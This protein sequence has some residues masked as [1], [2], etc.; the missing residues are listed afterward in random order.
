LSQHIQDYANVTKMIFSVTG[1]F[2]S[3]TSYW[4][5]VFNYSPSNPSDK[6]WQILGT[7][8]GSQ[9]TKT[10]IFTISGENCMDFIDEN[11]IVKTWMF[12]VDDLPE[13]A[14]VFLDQAKLLVTVIEDS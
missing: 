7:I 1:I 10:W 5:N 14:T 2:P 9:Q 8:S 11:G 13:G 6:H 12:P 3:N 4:F